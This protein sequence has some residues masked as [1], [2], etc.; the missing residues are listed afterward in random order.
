VDDRGMSQL[1]A[2][3]ELSIDE[4]YALQDGSYE[5]VK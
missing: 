2:G 5:W 1:Q 3:V 4:D